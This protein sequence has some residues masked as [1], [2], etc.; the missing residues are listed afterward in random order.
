MRIRANLAGTAIVL[1]GV[2][3]PLCWAHPAMAQHAGCDGSAVTHGDGADVVGFC[4]ARSGEMSPEPVAA[5]QARGPDDAALRAVWDASTCRA[6]AGD[7]L[8]GAYVSRVMLSKFTPEDL[9]ALGLDPT[10]PMGIFRTE[11]HLPDGSVQ[12]AGTLP[13]GGEILPVGAGGAA[14]AP[15]NPVDVRDEARARIRPTSP[16]VGMSPAGTDGVPTIVQMPTW[17]WVNPGYWAAWPEESSRGGVT[18]RV[19]GTPVQARWVMGDGSVKTCG[20]GVPWAPGARPDGGECTYTYRRD[21]SGEATGRFTVSVTVT[22]RYEWWLN[23]AP[24][25]VFGTSVSPAA[26]FPVAVD[27]I[28]VIN[29]GG[30]RP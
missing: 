16:S 21:S 12:Q 3:V 13:G 26:V 25:G 4:D 24:Q 22:W 9:T 17:M 14:I 11:C 10:V 20:A 19:V 29:T 8:P 23:G 7:W 15:V 2:S 1:A 6:V 27:E 18:V 30:P 28:Q 5:P